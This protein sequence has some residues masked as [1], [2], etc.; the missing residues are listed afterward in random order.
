MPHLWALNLRIYIATYQGKGATAWS[1]VNTEW[2]R[3]RKSLFLRLPYVAIV[4]YDCRG[5]AAIAAAATAGGDAELLKAALRVANTLSKMPSRWAHAMALLTKAGVASVKHQREYASQLLATAE[6]AFQALEM[7]QYVAACQH[8]RGLLAGPMNGRTLVAAAEDWAN[9][10][11]V[12]VP[13]KIF[14]MLAPGRWTA[15][16]DV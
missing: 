8:R 6:V 12:V 16:I 13:S 11:A 3:V 14:D 9:A 4:A 10:Q 2:P 5:R 7:T 15:N 1:L